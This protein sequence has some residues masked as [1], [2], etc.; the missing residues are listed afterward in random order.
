MPDFRTATAA[1]LSAI[2]ALL[3][4]DPLGATRESPGSPAYAEALAAI[5]ANPEDQVLLAVDG[6]AILGTLQLTFLPGL[7]RTGM[8]RAQIEG[9]RVAR[10]ARGQGIG[11]ALLEHAIDLS[12]Q[13]GCGLV[14]LTTDRTRQEAHR[15]Y[16]GLGFVGSH[17][18]MK[19]SL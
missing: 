6:E 9:V 4:D 14:Q 16:E 18:G 11:R 2:T 10:S 3:A 13:R 1:D 19:R 7:S 15:F 5:L 17:T 8:W 12:R